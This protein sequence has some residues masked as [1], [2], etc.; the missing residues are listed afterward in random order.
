MIFS[1]AGR[2]WRILTNRRFSDR[3]EMR[4]VRF[5]NATCTVRNTTQIAN[6]GGG[7]NKRSLVVVQ[8][9]WLPT[10]WARGRDVRYTT[11]SVDRR[12]PPY[13]SSDKCCLD[14]YFR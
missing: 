7:K 13:F 14:G 5:F 12:S 9:D 11:G 10:T 2:R 3:F 6:R 1:W 4:H 8:Q